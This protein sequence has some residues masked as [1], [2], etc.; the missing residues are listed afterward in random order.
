M[1]QTA[2]LPN[3]AVKDRWQPVVPPFRLRPLVRIAKREPLPRQLCLPGML[4]DN[5]GEDRLPRD[6]DKAVLCREADGAAV[7]TQPR[8]PNCGG[9]EF[10][11][12]GDCTTCW[13]P[14]VVG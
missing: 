1:L 6:D 14:G 8:C 2:L 12:D 13:E 5:S 11:D 7:S 4:T 10:D 3:C 9:S